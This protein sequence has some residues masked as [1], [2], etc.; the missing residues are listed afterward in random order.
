MARLVTLSFLVWALLLGPALC[1]A[2]LV[3]H[4]C[5]CNGSVEMQCQHDESCSDDPCASLLMIQDSGRRSA[6]D[7]DFDFDLPLATVTISL[8]DFELDA[9]RGPFFVRPQ[10]PPNRLNL[11]YASSDLPLRI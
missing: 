9:V 5:D 7:L 11:P 1:M 3:E 6:L 2:G 10:Q 4:L 8:Q